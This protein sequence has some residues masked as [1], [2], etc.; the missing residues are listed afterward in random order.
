MKTVRK[1]VFRH[2]EH[3]RILHMPLFAFLKR[4]SKIHDEIT[5]KTRFWACWACATT[6]Y[7][8]FAFLKQFSKI[9][10]DITAKTRFLA[11]WAFANTAYA[12]ICVS[13]RDF[14]SWWWKQFRNAFFRHVEHLRLLH[15]PIFAFLKQFSNIDDEIT[16][17]T[18]FFG[19]LNICENC[20]C[21]MRVSL[22]DFK[23]WWW[24][25]CKKSVFWHI[26]HFR[27]LHMPLFAFLE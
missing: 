11:C 3:L 18:R 22:L 27:I 4:F 8:L 7:A 13:E 20:I 9:H 24:K 16:A 23:T 17:K 6:A 21:H 12:Y 5:A 15:M 14:K 1:R 25:Q 26:E 10:D 2:V 19:M